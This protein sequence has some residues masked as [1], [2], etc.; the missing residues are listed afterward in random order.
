[1]SIYVKKPERNSRSVA[2]GRGR[3]GTA[4]RF[5]TI[6]KNPN[7]VS[8]IHSE[9]LLVYRQLEPACAFLDFDKASLETTLMTP[10]LKLATRC[11]PPWRM[12]GAGNCRSKKT[13]LSVSRPS[14]LLTAFAQI[15]IVGAHCC[16]FGRGGKSGLCKVVLPEGDNA[17]SLQP[18]D[19]RG[20]PVGET[21]KVTKNRFEVYAKAWARH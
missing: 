7:T 2:S 1:V 6:L 17:R 5:R 9:A 15:P 13:G 16:G 4:R 19:L 3:S 18:V 12:E 11:S 20:R 14:I 8:S 10:R 21:I